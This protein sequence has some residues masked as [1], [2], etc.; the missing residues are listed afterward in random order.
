MA[1]NFIQPSLKFLVSSFL[2]LSLPIAKSGSRWRANHLVQCYC[3]AFPTD[4]CQIKRSG[5]W[6]LASTCWSLNFSHYPLTSKVLLS[7][8]RN[9]LGPQ[10]AHPAAP[11]TTQLLATTYSHPCD[12]FPTFWRACI[13]QIYGSETAFCF[14]G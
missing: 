9:L 8:P 3:R 13:S 6:T 14:F 11:S 7:G 12:I 1:I 5:V 4:T 2:L 10:I